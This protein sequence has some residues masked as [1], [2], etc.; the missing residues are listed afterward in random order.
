M[1]LQKFASDL[2][3]PSIMLLEA[4]ASGAKNSRISVAQTLMAFTTAILNSFLSP[5]EKSH[6]CRF[7][8]I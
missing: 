8:N 3:T 4:V 7:R 2:L 6:S 5:M 1:Q